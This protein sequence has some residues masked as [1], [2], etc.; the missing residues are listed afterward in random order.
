M[1]DKQ[2][3]YQQYGIMNMQLLEWIAFTMAG[4]GLPAYVDLDKNNLGKIKINQKDYLTILKLGYNY[5]T[6]NNQ[7]TLNKFPTKLST[8]KT[9]NL[10]YDQYLLMGTYIMEWVVKQNKNMTKLPNNVTIQGKY[11]VLRNDYINAIKRVISFRLKNN[12][13]NPNTVRVVLDSATNGTA[14]WFSDTDMALTLIANAIGG[15]FNNEKEFFNLVCK[16]EIYSYY[17]NNLYN[18][19]NSIQRLKTGY[20]LNCV[21]FSRIGAYV[22]E[23][24]K[25]TWRIIH[26]KCTTGGHVYIQYLINGKWTNYDLAAAASNC[27]K[28]GKIG[29]AWCSTGSTQGIWTKNNTLPNWIGNWNEI[30]M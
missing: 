7:K 27:A 13:K 11:R 17:N 14:K 30:L 9:I 29:F 2:L 18:R 1:T 28:N 5:R 15:K 3:T 16:N 26:K 21:D 23:K 24:L 4:I 25:L 6:V 12:S 20:G 19:T 8:G 22:M 10:T